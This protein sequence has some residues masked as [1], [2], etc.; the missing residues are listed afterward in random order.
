[1]SK[2]LK[3]KFPLVSVVIV[4][5][6]GLRH[7][8]R[9]LPSLAC[10]SYEPIEII[11]VDNNSTD[12]SLDY[13]KK[14]FP[15]AK[16]ISNVINKGFAEANNQGL[17]LARGAYVLLLNNDTEVTANFLEPLVEALQN[18]PRLGAVQSKIHLM[19]R[20]NSLDATGSFLT[21]TGFLAHEGIHEIDRGQYDNPRDIF[22]PKGACVLLKKEVLHEVGFFDDIFFAYFEETDLFWR[23]WLAGYRVSFIPSSVIYHAMGATSAK[24]KTDFIEFHSFKNRI[25]SLYKNLSNWHLWSIL[26]PHGFVVVVVG[27]VF[28]ISGKF[29]RARGVFKALLWNVRH[30]SD[31]HEK[32]RQVQLRVRKV[33]DSQIFPIILKS[34]SWQSRYK[35]FTGYF[36]IKHR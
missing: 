6:N 35:N 11:I 34:Q 3:N 14:E 30:W 31:N 26:L 8:K 32:R 20:P 12:G 23:F 28:L 13:I 10:I 22:S 9:C 15:R 33:S 36:G 2:L 4:T 19:D 16:I 7:L 25:L 21:R 18:D 1:M 5:M 17:Y 27:F 29:L 24:L